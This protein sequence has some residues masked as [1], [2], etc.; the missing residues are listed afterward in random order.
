MMPMRRW[1]TGVEHGHSLHDVKQALGVVSG[2]WTRG[3]KQLVELASQPS[4]C[5]QP[6]VDV[7]Q[8]VRQSRVELPRKVIQRAGDLSQRKSELPQQHDPVEA[9]EVGR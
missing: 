7:G 4:S 8:V 6:P 2:S 1:N 9:L 3:M 5:L